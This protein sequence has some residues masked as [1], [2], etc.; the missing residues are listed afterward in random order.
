M[1]SR[2]ASELYWMARFLER[3]E[4]TAR[5]LDVTQTM[6]LMPLIDADNSELIAPLT[7]TGTH[8]PFMARYKSVSMDNLLEFFGLDEENPSS[9]FNCIRMA[10]DNA[11]SVRGKIPSEVWES[12]NATW[13]EIKTLR[14]KG[15]NHSSAQAFLDWVKERSHLFRGATF[16]TIMRGDVLWFIRL[17]TFIERA[18]NTARILDVKYQVIQEDED[19]VREFYRWNSLLRSVGAYESHQTLYKGLSRQSVAELLILRNE[20][21]R[22]LR[23]SLEEVEQLLALIEG[24]AG[25]EP[26]RLTT[27]LNANLRFGKIEEVFTE[28][29]HQYLTRFLN[30]IGAIGQSI[31]RA[32]LEAL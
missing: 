7:I 4:N 17:G 14:K 29:V 2:T 12:I 19:S 20:V 21:P 3:A 31:H 26:R 27:V 9:I 13:L 22:S 1:L 10:R 11:H 28:G 16:G 5:M 24:N 15:I 6:S 30:D 18:D 23:A 8:E 25:H 32:Y